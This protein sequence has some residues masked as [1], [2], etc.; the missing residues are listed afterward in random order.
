[1]FT[2]T[3]VAGAVGALAVLAVLGFLLLPRL[4]RVDG[5]GTTPSDVPS[6]SPAPSAT[7]AAAPGS[8]VAVLQPG[9]VCPTGLQPACQAGV[10]SAGTYTF[11]AGGVTPTDLSFTVPPGSTLGAD[12][13]VTKRIDDHATTFVTWTLT[14]LFTDICHWKD[15]MVPAGSSAA[16]VAAA[17]A[18]QR[19]RT[20]SPVT[21]VT[22]DGFPAK[23]IVL[24]LPRDSDPASFGCD[25]PKFRLWPDTG[26][27]LSGGLL[28]GLPESTDVTYIVDGQRTPLAIVAR[29]EPNSSA[30]DRQELQSIVD[31]I[32]IARP[33]AS[34]SGSAGVSAS[35]SASVGAST[36]P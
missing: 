28:A 5:V 8:S 22:V 18:A 29:Q 14:H 6:A 36:T 23:R 20:A 35:A 24:T 7:P 1:M 9:V 4:G 34:P 15:A 27:D 19:G 2:P 32:V 3:R 25:R 10:L 13:F 26:G 31:S 30:A 11:L 33:S 16:V 17:L 12:G 21:D